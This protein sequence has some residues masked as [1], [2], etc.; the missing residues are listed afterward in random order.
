MRQSKI[1]LDFDNTIAQS[2]E[3][4]LL[5]HGHVCD[6]RILGWDFSPY[7]STPEEQ[8][9]MVNEFN[10]D[11]FWDK[12]IPMPGIKEWLKD[13]YKHSIPIY[14]CSKRFAG[15]FTRVIDWMKKEGLDEYITDYFFI[16]KSYKSKAALLD[17]EAIIIDDNPKCFG[18]DDD[19]RKIRF[20]SYKYGDEYQN[21]KEQYESWD[22]MP[23]FVSESLLYKNN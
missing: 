17:K 5:M 12:L 18:D 2:A 14:V 20:K 8:A 11:E 16:Y 6:P 13:Q 23:H 1:I 7:A 4:I 21:Y 15:Q 10:T 19:A 9:L 22:E 3:T